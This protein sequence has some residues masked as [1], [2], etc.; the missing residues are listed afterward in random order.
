[1]ASL[2]IIC[3]QL[4]WSALFS[5]RTDRLSSLANRLPHLE[6]ALSSSPL[7]KININQSGFSYPIPLIRI[8]TLISVIGLATHYHCELEDSQN[9][10]IE[11]DLLGVRYLFSRQSKTNLRAGECKKATNLVLE[12]KFPSWLPIESER[13]AW[14]MK[15]VQVRWIAREIDIAQRIK[16]ISADLLSTA[17][18]SN[19]LQHTNIRVSYHSLTHYHIPPSLTFSE[20]LTHLWLIHSRSPSPAASL[21]ASSV[22][23]QSHH[24]TRKY[25][26]ATTPSFN[27]HQLLLLPRLHLLSYHHL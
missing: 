23:E 16:L 19:K 2:N 15:K 7:A 1:M 27:F 17:S 12:R 25:A 4:P 21:I 3:F 24:L 6:R 9:R 10:S 5:S 26:S 22:L 18:I 8:P 13:G 20:A 11:W 14:P